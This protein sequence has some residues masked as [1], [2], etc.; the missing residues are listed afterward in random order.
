M[1]DID[2]WRPVQI[3]HQLADDIMECVSVY[4]D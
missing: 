1:A 3:G 4:F 2:M